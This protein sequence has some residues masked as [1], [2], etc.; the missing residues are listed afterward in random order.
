MDNAR[1]F[2]NLEGKGP[3]VRTLVGAGE[4]QSGLLPEVGRIAQCATMLAS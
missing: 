4:E 1:A 3:Q 2:F